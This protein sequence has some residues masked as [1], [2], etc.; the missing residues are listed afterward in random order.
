MQAHARATSL[1]PDGAESPLEP[2]RAVRLRLDAEEMVL[3]QNRD[4]GGDRGCD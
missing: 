4:S 2:L 1:A 3:A